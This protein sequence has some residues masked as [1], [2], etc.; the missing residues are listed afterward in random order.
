MKSDKMFS[1]EHRICTKR[2]NSEENWDVIQ[3]K[4]LLTKNPTSGTL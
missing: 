4:E 3:I 1:T 2:L